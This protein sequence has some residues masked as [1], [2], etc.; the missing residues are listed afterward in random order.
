MIRYAITHVN[1]DGMR[2]LTFANQGR[3]LYETREIAE[4]SVDLL[5]DSLR[6]KVLGDMAD[7][8]EVRQVDC[9]ESGDAKGIFFDFDLDAELK[10]LQNADVQNLFT[11]GKS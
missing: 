7:T 1:K 9:Y 6:E 10:K 5:K 11:E 3:N 2:T 4:A 8:L